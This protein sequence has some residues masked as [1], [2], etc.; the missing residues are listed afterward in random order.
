M[1]TKGM[2][3]RNAQEAAADAL[4]A[5]DGRNVVDRYRTRFTA[6]AVL[7]DAEAAAQHERLRALNEWTDAGAR[8]EAWF[9][10]ICDAYHQRVAVARETRQ[11]TVDAAER[12]HEAAAAALTARR[13]E[14]EQRW[15][16]AR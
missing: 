15:E 9:G 13:R 7:A 8:D 3:D 14:Y 4:A 5:Q 12:R 6:D 2:W 16:T 1:T 10:R 11:R